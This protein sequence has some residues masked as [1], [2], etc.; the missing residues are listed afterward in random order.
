MEHKC[1]HTDSDLSFLASNA[2]M[3]AGSVISYREH[4]VKMSYLPLKSIVI[5]DDKT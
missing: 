3:W 4:K 1:L 2:K 5:S